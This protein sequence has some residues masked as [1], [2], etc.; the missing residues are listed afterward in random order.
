MDIWVFI[1]SYLRAS[2]I[3]EDMLYGRLPSV[4]LISRAKIGLRGACPLLNSSDTN[5]FMYGRR[6]LVS[7][8]RIYVMRPSRRLIYGTSTS[9]SPGSIPSSLMQSPLIYVHLIY[10]LP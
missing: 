9:L 6:P 5:S 2:L 1:D 7:H 10:L 3:T 4:E 8:N